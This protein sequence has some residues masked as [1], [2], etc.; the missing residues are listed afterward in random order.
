ME[1]G[2]GN[3]IYL[4]IA[5]IVGIFSSLKKKKKPIPMSPPDDGEVAEQTAP[6]PPKQESDFES[7]FEALLGQPAPQPYQ[8]ET[9]WEEEEEEIFAEKETVLDSVPEQKN[10]LETS[11]EYNEERKISSF[12]ALK[13]LYS[14]EEDEEEVER[15]EI[16]WR[17]AIIYKEILDRKYN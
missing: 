17:Q 6:Q 11:I 14:D 4:I 1:D 13:K 12:D 7:V 10:P 3:I 2:W 9:E 16:D 5:A 8:E 15:E